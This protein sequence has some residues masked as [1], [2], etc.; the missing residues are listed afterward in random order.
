VARR[1]IRKT[2]LVATIGPACDSPEAIKAMIRAGMDVARLN[3]SHGTHEEHRKRL[4]C[5]RECSAELSA[6]VAVMLDTKGVK[7]RTGRLAGGTVHLET[8]APFTLYTD[9]RTGDAR[10]VSVSYQALP[11]QVEPG[12]TILIDDGVI[13]LEVLAVESGEIRCRIRRGGRLQDRKGVNLPGAALGGMPAMSPENRADLAFAVREDVDYVA[14]SFVRSSADVAE[15]R[16][17]LHEH[18]GV[19]IPIIA[20]I[21]SAAGVARLDEI[22]AEADGVMVAR[23][24]LGVELPLQEVPIVQKKIIRTTVMNGKPVITA[25]QMLD[26]MQRNPTPTR[27]EV[28]DV[29]NAI[30]DGTSAVMLSNE[31]AAGAYPVEA[32]RTMATLALEA[33]ASLD[34]YGHLQQIRPEGSNV[35]TD[36]VSQAAITMAT[37]LR[38]AAIVA[39]TESGFTA[40]SIS[41]YRPRCPILGVTRWERVARRFAMN[42]GVTGVRFEGED[43]SDAAQVTFAV[44]RARQLGIAVPGDVVV[45]TSGVG[46]QTGSTNMIRVVTVTDLG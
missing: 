21:E 23:G 22:V 27:A 14:A 41:K 45:A 20:K 43:L 5:I 46:S 44:E 9:G 37:H 13:E 36:A 8:G 18:G 35:V 24:D 15:I 16:R 7:I 31:T 11:E 34:E 12:S 26:S 17:V 38:A 10:G 40:R 19:R 2:K 4:E 3:F 29:A 25:T 1:R 33:E 39:L 32:V 30:F 28:S 6:N 42:W